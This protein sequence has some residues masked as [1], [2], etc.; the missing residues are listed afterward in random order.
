MR[1]FGHLERSGLTPIQDNIQIN[2][3]SYHYDFSSRFSAYALSLKF[4]LYL[5][6]F[7]SSNPNKKEYKSSK[8]LKVELSSV[9]YLGKNKDFNW[10]ENTKTAKGISISI[11]GLRQIKSSLFSIGFKTGM[12]NFSRTTEFN[13]IY[14]NKDKEAIPT[15]SMT[16]NQ[17]ALFA[18][19]ELIVQKTLKRI[20]IHA[21]L[22]SGIMYMLRPSLEYQMTTA[23]G[24]DQ[25]NPEVLVSGLIINTHRLC[26][27]ST[28]GL[29]ADYRLYARHTIGI[30]ASYFA[31][32]QFSNRTEFA[33]VRAV[34][35][36]NDQSYAY[37]FSTT[38]IGIKAGLRYTY[39]F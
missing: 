8:A 9:N 35:Q 36:V 3:Q 14:N 20:T 19:P 23:K 37:Y 7:K 25:L 18:Y 31:S 32:P 39:D 30:S 5:N 13:F 38:I 17:L 26:N 1:N 4:A 11:G 33:P 29:G 2:D 34:V 15:G 12:Q 16:V 10:G 28:F 6:Q 24:N 21:E 27:F 22:G